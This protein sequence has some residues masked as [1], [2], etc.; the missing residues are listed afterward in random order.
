MP[1]IIA[2][3]KLAG[4]MPLSAVTGRADIMDASTSAGWA[5]PTA[6]TLSPAPPRL[7]SIQTM[8]DLD[9][10]ARATDIGE[11][12]V[13][14]LGDIAAETDVIAEVR[15][16]GAMIAAEIV[17][18]G[19]LDPDPDLTKRISAACLK[20]GVLVLTAGAYGNILRFLPPLVI[21]PELLDEASMWWLQPSR[22]RLTPDGAEEVPHE[23]VE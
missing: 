8:K 21:S 2:T 7:A 23:E 6:A 20:Q 11:I 19:T 10:A 12:L 9:L 22:P 13:G 15:G 5:A 3:A 17:K 16:R 4:G 18:P 1:D 14:R